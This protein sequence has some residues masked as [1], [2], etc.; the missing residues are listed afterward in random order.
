[1]RAYA[2]RLGLALAGC[3]VAAVS[4]VALAGATAP[5]NFTDATTSFTDELDSAFT[6]ALPLGGGIVALF[7]GW[8][9]MKRLLHG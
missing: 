1:M 5:Y 2:K 4:M 9:V 6:V 8:K 7:V 3:V